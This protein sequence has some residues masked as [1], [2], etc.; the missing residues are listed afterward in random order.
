VTE[1]H[2]LHGQ[3]LHQ[4]I[5]YGSRARGDAQDDSDINTLIV[6]DPVEDFWTELSRIGDVANRIS[7]DCDVVISAIP[8]DAVELRDPKTPLLLVT[9]QEGVRVA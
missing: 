5:L 8:I 9:R 6:L 7:L 2:A 3:R 4:V 1:I